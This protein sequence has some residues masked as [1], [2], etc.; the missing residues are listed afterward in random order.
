MGLECKSKK[1]GDTWSIRKV[2][3]WSKK[4]RKKA[5]RILPRKSTSHRIHPLNNT[6]DDYTLTSPDGQY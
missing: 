4:W 2:W 1:S 3:P 5:N 6:R